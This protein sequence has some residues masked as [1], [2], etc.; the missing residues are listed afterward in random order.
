MVLV[1]EKL[2]L[3]LLLLAERVRIH[4]IQVAHEAV[5]GRSK[6]LLL[7]L[8]LLL[9]LGLDGWCELASCKGWLD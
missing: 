4:P 3:L 7:L 5:W 1:G 8:L 9:D 6:V 2:L